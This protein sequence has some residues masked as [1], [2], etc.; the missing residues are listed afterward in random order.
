MVAVAIERMGC[1]HFQ[2]MDNRQ[3]DFFPEYIME[4]L[5][6]PGE[7]AVHMTRLLNFTHQSLMK[8]AKVDA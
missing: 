6:L 3:G 5:G 7:D 4:K 1:F 2:L 8:E